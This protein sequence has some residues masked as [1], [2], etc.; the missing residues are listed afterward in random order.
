MEEVVAPLPC[1]GEACGEGGGEVRGGPGAIAAGD[2]AVDY[3]RAEILFGGVVGGW[4]VRAVEEDEEVGALVAIAGLEAAGLARC[5][6][7]G[8]GE[9]G[10]EDEAI[11]GF[12]DGAAPSVHAPEV[13]MYEWEVH[14]EDR[15]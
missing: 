6:I 7:G 2:L 14:H 11:D 3:S 10:V 8:L 1:G 13:L 5:T 12:V 15:E 4:H 9:Q